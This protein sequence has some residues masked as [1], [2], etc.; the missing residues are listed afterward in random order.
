MAQILLTQSWS[1]MLLVPKNI[2]IIFLVNTVSPFQI[3]RK[4]ISESNI[5]RYSETILT[6]KII[7]IFLEQ[8]VLH[9]RTV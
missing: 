5:I 8:V 7:M 6:R 9:S 2:I 4:K 3:D 1:V